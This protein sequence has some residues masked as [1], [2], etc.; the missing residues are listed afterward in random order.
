M[1][2]KFNT[3]VVGGGQAGLSMGYYLS[4]QKQNYVIL[5]QASSLAP[6]WRTRWDSFTLVLPN[7]TLQMPDFAYQ[8]NDPDGFLA[9]DEMVRYLEQFAA[10]FDCQIR[11]NCKVT[12]IEKHPNGDG[13]LLRTSDHLYEGE[14]V[15]VATGSFQKPR[16]PALSTDISPEITQIHTSEYRSPNELPPGAVLVVGSGQSGCQIAEELYRQGRKVYLC[17]GKAMRIPRFYRGKDS[18][19]WLGRMNF[20]DQTVDTL[21]SPKEKFTAN[22]FTSGKD[23]G[24]SLD[25]HQFARDGVIL[26]GRL[27]DAKGTRIWLS[28]DLRENLAQID[29]FVA[30]LKKKI[31]GFIEAN[32]ITAQDSTQDGLTGGYAAEMIEE[33]D[34]SAEGIQ[35]IIW[36][37]GY[38]FD[39][40]WIQFPVLDEDGYP[41]QNRG[42]SPVP[43]LFFLGIHWMYKRKSGLP[44]G[45]GQDAAYLAQVIAT[46][47]QPVPEEHRS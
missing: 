45:V 7:W 44:W 37:T 8:G 32:H 41:I 40:S 6:A 16:I 12:S 28:P 30:E 46:R 3:I 42:V 47:S 13:F 39:Y 29:K 35:T 21:A 33:L 19:W 34:L 24:R 4:Q 27:K 2:E 18:I 5:E 14:N 20:F 43:G 38:R 11:F 17:V 1:S 26:L 9:R 31:D 22:P 23:G 10:T 25:L 15:V 36:A